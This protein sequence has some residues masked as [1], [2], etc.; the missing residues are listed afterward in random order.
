M[1]ILH[2]YWSQY[3]DIAKMGG[4][5][6]VYL[7]NIIKVQALKNIVYTLAGGMEYDISGKC[8]IKKI[9]NDSITEDYTIVNSPMLA[10]SKASFRELDLYIKDDILA[11]VLKKIIIEKGPFDIIHIHSF[12]GLT[13]SCLKLKCC[14]IN[15]KFIL[16]LHNYYSFCPQVNLW[17]KNEISCTDY[18]DGEKCKE[19]GNGLPSP[20]FVKKIYMLNTYLKRAHLYSAYTGLLRIGRK[21]T[22]HHTMHKRMIDNQLQGYIY[23][24]F[25]EKNIDYIN[26]YIDTVICVSNKVKNIAVGFGVNPQKCRKLYIGTNFAKNQ[27]EKPLYMYNNGIFS[28]IYMGYMRRDKGFYFLYN[29]LK[30][31]PKKLSQKIRVVIAARFDDMDAVNGL[32][33]IRNKFASIELYD[34]YNHENI[35]EIIRNVN[36]GIVPVMWEDN[37]PQVAMELKS[38]GIPVLSS[39]LGGASELTRCSNFCFQAGNNN[40]FMEKMEN[41]MNNPALLLQYYKDGIKLS[42]IEEHCLMLDDIYCKN[43]YK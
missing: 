33:K 35:H 30:N 27:L 40:S 10:P 16:T 7:N 18:C 9:N 17:Y 15:T 5:I 41:I 39:N 37:L 28:I 36:L 14:F 29:C 6:Q 21:K 43:T 25:R 13:L 3:N 11:E 22:K 19:C 34:G 4:G 12:E 32:H 8:K 42:T 38:M 20:K 2:Y 23:K 31:M 26:R 1:K 24:E